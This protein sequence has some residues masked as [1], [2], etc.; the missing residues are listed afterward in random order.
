M[1]RELYCGFE[2]KAVQEHLKAEI[3][4]KKTFS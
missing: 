1:R 4:K 2:Q 3:N